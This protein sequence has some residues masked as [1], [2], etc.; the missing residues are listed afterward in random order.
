MLRKP[1]QRWFRNVVALLTLSY[2]YP[3]F[4]VS[5]GV[6][7]L[8]IASALLY[9]VQVF[10]H[11]LLKVLYLPINVITLG[12]FKWLLVTVHLLIVAYVFRDV[13][14]MPFSYLGFEFFGIEIPPGEINLIL[15]VIVGSIF[16]R[17][18]RKVLL[19]L[20]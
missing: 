1:L 11:P 19:F 15:S 3:G 10:L 14:F 18:I 9:F 20:M 7:S 2:F 16:Y 17:F 4:E 12:M 8:L 13:L 5:G 6:R